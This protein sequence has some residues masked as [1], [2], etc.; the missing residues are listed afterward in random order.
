MSTPS[1]TTLSCDAP[2]FQVVGNTPLVKITDQ[3]YG[4]LE[5]FNPTGSIKDR[6]IRGIISQAIKNGEVTSETILVE[7]TSG[8]TGIALSG[9]GAALGLEVHIFMPCNMSQSRKDMMRAFGATVHETGPNDFLGAIA[10]RDEMVAKDT[11]C[12]TPSQFANVAN[13]EAHLQSTCPEINQQL[14]QLAPNKKWEAYINGSGTG[15]TISAFCDFRK[16]MGL[17]YKVVMTE[18][19]ESAETHGIQ[20]IY[21][22]ADFLMSRAN[23]DYTWEVKTED[24]KKRAAQFAKE[25][26]ILVGI[27]SGANLLL[28]ERYVKEFNP[29]GIVVCMLCDRGERYMDIFA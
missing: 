26:G 24:A 13:R 18:P 6:M 11:K 21:D 28:A 12:W 29:E 9:A 5:T 7:A 2:F 19:E 14:T 22:G 3:I 27:S 1:S 16:Q 15:G 25:Q 20:G 8:N 17:D 4:K 10:Q 23:V